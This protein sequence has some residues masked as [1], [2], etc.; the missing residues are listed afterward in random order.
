M[1]INLVPDLCLVPSLDPDSIKLIVLDLPCC[2]V[3][4]R[5]VQGLLARIENEEADEVEDELVEKGLE[6]MEWSDTL[7]EMNSF[8]LPFLHD[9]ACSR[10]FPRKIS[11]EIGK[12]RYILEYACL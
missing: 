2:H 9:S 3:K 7:P 10:E 12:Y 5:R 6:V 4:V 1:D 8:P 11:R